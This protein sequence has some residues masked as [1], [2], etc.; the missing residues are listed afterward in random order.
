VPNIE[1]RT[2]DDGQRTCP[3]YVEF[4]DINKCGKISASVSFIKKKFVT[5]HGHM[6]VKF[7]LPV[8]LMV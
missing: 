7:L 5:M 6:N 3:K 4:L 8:L 1:W 2:P